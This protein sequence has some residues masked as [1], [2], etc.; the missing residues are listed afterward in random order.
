MPRQPSPPTTTQQPTRLATSASSATVPNIGS[1]LIVQPTSSG[2]PLATS[3]WKTV[4]ST[5]W[6]TASWAFSRPTGP[7]TGPSCLRTSSAKAWARCSTRSTPPASATSSAPAWSANPMARPAS[8]SPTVACRR[9]IPAS[10][11]TTP[12]GNRVPA[13]PSWR[14]NSCAASWSSWA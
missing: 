12:S 8:M 10:A 3:G 5:R 4:S 1:W 9:S 6:K 7:K 14:P 11:R 13:T 2:N